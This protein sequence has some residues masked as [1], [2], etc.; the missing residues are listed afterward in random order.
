MNRLWVGRAVGP[1]LDRN[2][3]DVPPLALIT[4]S[5]R[6]IEG[7]QASH[8]RNPAAGRHLKRSSTGA[9]RHVGN[10]TFALQCVGQVM[11]RRSALLEHWGVTEPGQRYEQLV[12]IRVDRPE[13]A[14]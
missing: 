5:H 11:R 12:V 8:L 9:H 3:H 4:R 6:Y 1:H 7:D 2:N 14:Q 13:L 10:A